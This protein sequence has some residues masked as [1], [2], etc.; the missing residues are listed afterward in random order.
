VG[1][2]D[3]YNDLL[4]LLGFIFSGVAFTTGM[5]FGG[6]IKLDMFED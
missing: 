4:C 6:N 2:G 5:F 1:G 3:D